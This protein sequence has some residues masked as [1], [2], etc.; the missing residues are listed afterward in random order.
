MQNSK[1][2]KFVAQAQKQNWL[3]NIILTIDDESNI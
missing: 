3:I 2:Y 1:L